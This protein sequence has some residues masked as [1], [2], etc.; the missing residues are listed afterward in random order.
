MKLW[1]NRGGYFFI[2]SV[3]FLFVMAL[4]T[5]TPLAWH[6][7][8]RQDHSYPELFFLLYGLPFGFFMLIAASINLW[9]RNRT[10]K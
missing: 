3:L 2:F 10:K 1:L 5:F 4:F 6:M 9:I 7:T 8:G